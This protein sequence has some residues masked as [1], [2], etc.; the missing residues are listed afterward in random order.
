MENVK[1]MNNAG[2]KSMGA[3]KHSGRGHNDKHSSSN[4]QNDYNQVS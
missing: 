4:A 1:M 2:D 3:E